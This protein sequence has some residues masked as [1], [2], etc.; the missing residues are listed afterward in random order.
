MRRLIAAGLLGLALATTATTADAKQPRSHH[1]TAKF[2]KLN[3]CPFTGKTT[4]ACPGWVK[5]HIIA[6]CKGGA[7][8]VWNLQWQTVAEAKAKDKWEC[9]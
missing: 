3:P 8:G 4:G 2:Q 7:D 9:K 6:L 1:V 5:D